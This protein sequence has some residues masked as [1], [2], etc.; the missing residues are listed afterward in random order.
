MA[1]HDDIRDERD[2]LDRVL[3][4][5]LAKYASV[6][7]RT[8]MEE[9]ILANLRAERSR[10]ADRAWWRWGMA[11]A[12]T[13][14][15]VVAMTL[16]WRTGR[17]PHPVIT[18]H[19][20]VVKPSP[21]KLDTQVASRDQNIAPPHRHEPARKRVTSAS[22]PEPVVAATPKLDQFPSPQPL[23]NEEL[24]LAR[25][26]KDFPQEALLIARAQ[27]EYEIEIQKKMA[28][29]RA[30]TEPSGSDQQER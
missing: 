6:E 13:V 24:A 16:A 15:V 29:T 26:V 8:G 19:P 20:P 9:R 5:A 25:Y 7:P 1:N 12:V 14:V 28:E 10:V 4:A 17:P 22:R 30:E 11:V 21:Q 23:S 27:Q 2:D 18:N 3:D